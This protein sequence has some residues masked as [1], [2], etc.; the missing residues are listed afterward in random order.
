VVREE[1]R[2]GWSWWLYLRAL[3]G[4]G[5]ENRTYIPWSFIIVMIMTK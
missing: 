5:K 2:L 3:C 1:P 4:Y